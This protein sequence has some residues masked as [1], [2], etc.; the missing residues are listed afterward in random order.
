MSSLLHDVQMYVSLHSLEQDRG[1]ATQLR[2]N[3]CLRRTQQLFFGGFFFL[4]FFF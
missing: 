1:V 2:I 3:L 4:F